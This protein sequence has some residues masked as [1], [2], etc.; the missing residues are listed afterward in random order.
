MT[1]SIVPVFIR[2][3]W[4][5]LLCA[6]VG[7]SLAVPVSASGKGGPKTVHVREYTRKDGTHVQAH[8][9]KA[10][11]PRGTTVTTPSTTT[12]TTSGAPI[13]VYRDPITGVK[14]FTNELA[15]S[16]QSSVLS[17][18]GSLVKASAASRR[19]FTTAASTR[20]VSRGLVS[21]TSR[22]SS[23]IPRSAAAK[24]AFEV[25]TGYPNGRPGYVVDHIV[26]LACGGADTPANMQWQNVADAKAKDKVERKDCGLHT[27]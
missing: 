17:T 27:R 21:G 22:P 24:H 19:A 7:L 1:T 13:R 10:P 4:L 25:Q 9:R 23:R 8:D 18:V 11:E 14:T 2:N 26:P 3:V 16:L 5:C 15:P 6:L 12:P 20:A